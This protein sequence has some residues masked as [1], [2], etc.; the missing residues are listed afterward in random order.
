MD[1]LHDTSHSQNDGTYQNDHLQ[2]NV[3]DYIPPGYESEM[4]RRPDDQS[5]LPSLR[6]NSSDDVESYEVIDTSEIHVDL[7]KE[8]QQGQD[9]SYI[10]SGT[11]YVG[12]FFGYS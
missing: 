10:A 5:R 12:K 8:E 7:S 4:R 11:A 2:T 9:G 6:M 1:S 3:E